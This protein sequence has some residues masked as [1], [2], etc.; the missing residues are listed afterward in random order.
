MAEMSKNQTNA[1][2]YLNKIRAV[3]KDILAKKLEIEA[4][5]YKASGAG[6]IRYDKDRVQTSPQNYM[7]MACIDVVELKEEVEED[8]IGIEDMKGRA[9][10][11]VRKMVEPDQRAII[12]WYYLNGIDM[13]ATANNLHMSERNAYS[14]RDLALESF[15]EVLE[16]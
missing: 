16:P 2:E 12:E 5:E 3:E 9:Y 10:T 7:E 13:V 8:E 11:I 4:L 15:G 14:L 1:I 6:A